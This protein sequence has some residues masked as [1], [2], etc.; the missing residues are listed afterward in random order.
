MLKNFIAFIPFVLLS[1]TSLSQDLS[2]EKIWKNYEFYG[3]YVD[4]FRSMNNGNY[5]TKITNNRGGV[6]ITKHEFANYEGDGELIV[7]AEMLRYEG[8]ALEMDDYFFNEDE[9]KVLIT[10]STQGIYRHSYS[11]VYYLLDLSTKKLQPLDEERQP[12]TLAEY[13]PDGKKVSYI[14]ENNL[15]VKDIATGN[16]Q[17]ITFDGKQNEIINGTTDWVYEEEFA[18][19]KAYGWSPDSKYLAFLRFDERDVKEFT[20][21][22]FSELYPDP[23]TFKYP[24]TGEA[25]SVVTAHLYNIDDKSMSKKIDL[26]K[27]EYIPR[28]KWS[29]T[30]NK[31]IIQTMNRHQNHLKYHV[32]SP[33]PE[34]LDVK[35]F[36]EEKS[37]TYIDIDN[38][39]LILNDGNTILRTSES[40]GY[41]HI[42]KLSFDG[43]STQITSGEWDVIELLGIDDK[44]TTIYYS[45]AENG[46]IHKS[47]YRIGI[48]GTKKKLISSATGY[49]DADFSNGMKYFV[50]TYS[51]ANTPNVFTLCDN[52]GRELSVLED[53]SSLAKK[54]DGYKLGMKEFITFKGH[55]TELNG[56]IIKPVDF[57]PSK[58]YPVYINIY[59][60]PGANTVA[61]SW[62]GMNY[63][64]HQLLVQNGYIVVSVDPRGTMYRGEE[65]KKSTYLQ[66]GKLETEDFI[67]VAK[68]LQG[69]EYVDGS[70]I[71]IMGWSYG[72]Y[73]TSLAMTKGADYFKM[74]IAVAPVTNWRYYD[75]IYTERFMRTPQE[76]ADGYDDNSPINHVKKMKGKYLLIHGSGDD[77]VHYQNTMEMVNALV[78]ADK[79]FD[80]FIYPNKNHGIYGGNTRNHLFNM[81]FKYTL[82]NL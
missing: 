62:G 32:V 36:F 78:A 54:L 1:L 52:S 53:N 74:G 76:N 64:Y 66:L 26:G 45:S 44:N 51:N 24:K 31:L 10:T 82:E 58:K 69:L 60:G 81:M 57:D 80:L 21:M 59:G 68:E 9:S 3:E 65:F 40:N 14:F 38:N 75:N 79:Q 2:V 42:Y 41:N 5:F 8:V 67:A 61:D 55:E 63:M 6:S 33:S 48:K 22:Y 25:N 12:Q 17:Q 29:T 30:S 23:Y 27:Y 72:G 4:G 13:S 34:G 37:E 16:V 20:M 73:M 46:A 77:N 19:I 49:N 18:I 11:A 15:Y 70:R 71:G 7:G 47:I 50:K 35:M 43:K 56:W 28:L 39:L